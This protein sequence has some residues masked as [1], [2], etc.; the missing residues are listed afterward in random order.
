MSAIGRLRLLFIQP[1]EEEEN[2]RDARAVKFLPSTPIFY[3]ISTRIALD[4]IGRELPFKS[5]PSLHKPHSLRPTPTLALSWAPAPFV[6]ITSTSHFAIRHSP[7][8]QLRTLHTT[9]HPL[10]LPVNY[11]AS[12][13]HGTRDSNS[14]TIRSSHSKEFIGALG[15]TLI[16]SQ[17]SSLHLPR[18]Q[19]GEVSS[20]LVSSY[21]IT[22]L[23][24][25]YYAAKSLC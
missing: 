11:S 23:P 6:P 19:P 15:I 2:G 25:S 5:I 14:I 10:A 17:L 12:P 3:S 21:H 22:S 7:F 20:I 4:W 16:N 24:S 1:L 8:C 18:Y 13:I 9:H